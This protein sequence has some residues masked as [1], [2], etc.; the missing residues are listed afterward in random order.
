MVV[1]KLWSHERRFLS[2]IDFNRKAI[3][4][5]TIN[6]SF[7]Q[8]LGG[9]KIHRHYFPKFKLLPFLF[10]LNLWCLLLLEYSAANQRHWMKKSQMN[11]NGIKLII[12]ILVIC[13]PWIC[14]SM[15]TMT[16]YGE[17]KERGGRTK[18]EKGKEIFLINM[19][20][21]YTD[22]FKIGVFN[23]WIPSNKKL[24]HYVRIS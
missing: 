13:F 7:F 14:V 22:V 21:V 18:K 5:E 9:K 10:F 19:I 17:R 12:P 8:I 1:L 20:P 11:V 6:S 2:R 4:Q 23:S 15:T 3:K 24:Y 16:I